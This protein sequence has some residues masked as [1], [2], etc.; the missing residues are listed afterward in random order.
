MKKTIA[1]FVAVCMLLPGCSAPESPGQSEISSV[2][3]TQSSVP[4][5]TNAG[6]SSLS[7]VPDIS[8]SAPDSTSTSPLSTDANALLES[9][10]LASDDPVFA[11][12]QNNSIKKFFDMWLEEYMGEDIEA[13]WNYDTLA[14]VQLLDH[15]FNSIRPDVALYTCT[16]STDD[17]RCGYIIVS[18]G[19]DGPHI[20]QWSLHET[21]PYLYDLR[22]NIG[23]I[24]AA[25]A[26]TDIDLSTATAIRV[27]WM[28]TDKNR[29]DRIILFTDDKGDRYVCTLGDGDFT[30]EKW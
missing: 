9:Y 13:H 26:E 1:A 6:Q 25:L 2:P 19:E 24:T 4:D 14:P 18:Y 23:Q 29:G 27:E 15:E 5:N 16:F 20:Q 10:Y 28:D 3:A 12:L 7:S 8:D 11:Y 30:L 17:G 21:T 22:A